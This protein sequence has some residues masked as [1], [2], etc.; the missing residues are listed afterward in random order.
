MK[1]RGEVDYHGSRSYD[2]DGPVAR[3]WS[4]FMAWIAS[5]ARRRALKPA[6]TRK[7]SVGLPPVAQR[8]YSLLGASDHAPQRNPVDCPFPLKSGRQAYERDWRV[9]P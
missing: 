4:G 1:W 5:V 9:L 8:G 7:S 2:A 3:P 6:V